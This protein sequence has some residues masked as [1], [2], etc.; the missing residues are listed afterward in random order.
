MVVFNTYAVLYISNS[1]IFLLPQHFLLLM[2]FLVTCFI[3][4]INF[5]LYNM[6][7]S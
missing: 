7:L 4:L 2:N 3:L 6:D 5:G 1:S